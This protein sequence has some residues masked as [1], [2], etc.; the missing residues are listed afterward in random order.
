MDRSRFL[1]AFFI[2]FFVAFTPILAPIHEVGH[3][4]F[5]TGVSIT[6]WKTTWHTSY[7][8]IGLMGGAFFELIFYG[9]VAWIGHKI[10]ASN[11]KH[12]PSNISIFAWGYING[13]TISV[14]YSDDLLVYLPKIDVEPGHAIMTW[15][16]FSL[17]VLA[18]GWPQWWKALQKH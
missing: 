6:G 10:Y 5:G 16:I 8:Y 13:S 2:G 15:L 14:C 4:I 18:V 9:L 17:S 1:K 3:W 11:G 12:L 7:T